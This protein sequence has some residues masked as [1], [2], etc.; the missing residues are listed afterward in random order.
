MAKLDE[1]IYNIKNLKGGGLHSDDTDLSDEQIV[2]IIDYYRAKLISQD[3]NKGVKIFDGIDQT[4]GRLELSK[5]TTAFPTVEEDHLISEEFPTLITLQEGLAFRKV[6]KGSNAYD[7]IEQG[8]AGLIK[9]A[10]F[11]SQKGYFYPLG[12]RIVIISGGITIKKIP[13]TG[14]FEHP[15]KVIAFN[16]KA[17]VYEYNIEYPIP[18]KM[19]DTI[20]KMIIASELRLSALLPTDTVNNTKD[21]Q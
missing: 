21:D 20:Y 6:G 13:I 16:N 10:R 12:N 18:A 9:Y 8:R 15:L 14:V 5:D 17:E 7:Y 3:F 11:T 19:L 4:I 2:F 1:I